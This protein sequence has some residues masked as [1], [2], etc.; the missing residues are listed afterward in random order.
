MFDPP[1]EEDAIWKLPHQQKVLSWRYFHSCVVH[2]LTV[3]AAHIYMLTEVKYPL[4]PRVCKAMLEKKL[5]GD[6]KDESTMSNRHKDWLVQ[7]QT[8]LGKDFSNPFMADNLP[9]IIWLSTHHICV[10]EELASPQD[11]GLCC[12][13]LTM[14]FK[15]FDAANILSDDFKS[16]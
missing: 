8:A 16:C 1:S 5:L 2:C 12:E 3:E 9:K 11:Y 15:R 4:P 10:C 13:V 6:R 7:E 14:M